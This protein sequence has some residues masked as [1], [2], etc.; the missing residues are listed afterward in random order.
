MFAQ[1]KVLEDERRADAKREADTHGSEED[2]DEGGECVEH[3]AHRRLLVRERH[4]RLGEHD[5]DG[6]VEHALAKDLAEAAGER[7]RW[8]GSRV[9][10]AMEAREGGCMGVAIR[11]RVTIAKRSCRT[12]RAWNVARTATGSVAEMS[13]PKVSEASGESA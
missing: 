10:S 12:P 6:V 2:L 8:M 4:E 5:G 3:G 13:E 9:A 11:R 1:G 7:V